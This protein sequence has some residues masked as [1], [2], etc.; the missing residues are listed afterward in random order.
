M[1]ENYTPVFSNATHYIQQEEVEY[2]NK[3]SEYSK[4]ALPFFD[5]LDKLN[6]LK[7]VNGDVSI[8]NFIYLIKS[9]GH[10]AGFQ[11]V[12]FVLNGTKPHIIKPKNKKVLRFYYKNLSHFIYSKGVMHPGYKGD[13]FVS[14][15][16]SD[17]F[18][19]L[20]YILK[21]L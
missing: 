2:S 16:K 10:T 12:E 11:Y 5:S 1:K 9:H 13:D 18:S 14:K 4:Y 7:I 6:L 21:E 8:D 3:D 15:A 20:D 17:I 19:K